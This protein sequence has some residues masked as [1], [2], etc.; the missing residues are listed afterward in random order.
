MSAISIVIEKKYYN[1]DP[2]SSDLGKN[3]VSTSIELMNQLGFELFT[4]K[5]LASAIDST[6]ASIYRYF[7]NKH[8]L[9]VYITTWYWAW[10]E[11]M[12]D[13]ST[14]HIKASDEKL[15]EMIK[16]IC[17]A[18]EHISDI[19]MPGMQL[20]LLR[21]VVVSEADKTYLTKQV[22]EINNLGLFK[23]FKGLCH[24]VALV[25]NDINPAYP[26]PHA[27]VST[28]LEASHQQA[29][30]AQHLPSLTEISMKKKESLERQ[31]YT[32][33]EEFVFKLIR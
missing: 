21:K 8:K 7:D 14:H 1:K 31:V 5:K 28:I 23:G 13:V 25:V 9:L 3:I 6:E 26:Y 20:S 33:I 30:F 27:L 19:D 18:S 15:K 11:Y 16:I 12:I 29:F 17:H 24:K 22:D 32:F 2:Q 10:V 4:F